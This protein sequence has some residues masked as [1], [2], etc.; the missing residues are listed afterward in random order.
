[1][2]REIKPGFVLTIYT[3]N[4]GVRYLFPIRLGEDLANMNFRDA[5]NQSI[6]LDSK[7][8]LLNDLLTGVTEER[9]GVD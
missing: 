2:E 8:V 6:V 3:L 7:K 5:T 4:G 1:M 9:Y